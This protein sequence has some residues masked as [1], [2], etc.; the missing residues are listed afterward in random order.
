MTTSYTFCLKRLTKLL[1]TLG[2]KCELAIEWFKS[3][4]VIVNFDKFQKM[5]ISS[6]KN[7]S[8]KPV[9]KLNVSQITPR[10]LVTLSKLI[11][12]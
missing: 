10:S 1:K 2:N 5:I 6:K 7:V 8:C 12:N 9:L 3:N 11:T 4:D